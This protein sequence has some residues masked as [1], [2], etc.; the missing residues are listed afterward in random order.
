MSSGVF[1]FAAIASALATQFGATVA[2]AG[3]TAIKSATYL[4]PETVPPT[5]CV[6]VFPFDPTDF[7]YDPGR[8][9]T[10]L[11]WP[12]RFIYDMARDLPH[13]TA[14]LYA[15]LNVLY[16]TYPVASSIDLGLGGY[17][18]HAVVASVAIVRLEYPVGASW[19]CVE[20]R[21]A[22]HLTEHL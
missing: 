20:V 6:L 18:T 15:W 14:D 1:D 10:T 13:R 3:L 7:Q 12:V 2:P 4:M 17:V 5:P 21:V 16:A 22:T 19:P 11:V 8:R 9:N